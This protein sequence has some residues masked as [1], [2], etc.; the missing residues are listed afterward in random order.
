VVP[1][2]FHELDEPRPFL[3]PFL[4]LLVV[5]LGCWLGR[6]FAELGDGWSVAHTLRMMGVAFAVALLANL[7]AIALRGPSAPSKTAS[8]GP[9]WAGVIFALL[10]WAPL[11]EE[12]VFRYVLVGAL[13]DVSPVLAIGMSG[14]LFGLVHARGPLPKIVMGC[15]FAWLYAKSGTLWVPI[16]MHFAW[17]GLCVLA[18][19]EEI[20]RAVRRGRG[21]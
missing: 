18:C 19:H 1:V 6:P 15:L 4:T 21:Y 2:P 9:S 5:V 16:A 13:H 8:Y 20:D 11:A 17:N 14:V 12:L 7:V 3:P 10:I